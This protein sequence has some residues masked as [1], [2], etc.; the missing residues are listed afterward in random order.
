MYWMA[1]EL[2]TELTQLRYDP[3]TYANSKIS[4]RWALT[5]IE[6][7]WMPETSFSELFWNEGL[8]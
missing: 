3:V 8:A 4:V 1:S 2:F 7:H 5:E 6:D